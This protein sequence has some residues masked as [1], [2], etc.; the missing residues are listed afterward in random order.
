MTR[1]PINHLTA[2]DL[3]AFHSASLSA[4]VQEHLNECAECRALLEQDRALLASL[5]ALPR[6]GP[7]SGFADR[8][9]ARVQ[10]PQRALAPRFTP[11]RVALAAALVLTLGASIGWSLF[12]RALLVSWLD[13]GAGAIG[14]LLWSGLRVVASNLSQQPW[15]ATV[16]EFVAS[17]GRAP[18]AGSLLLLAYGGALFALRRLLVPPSPPVP[19]A[20]G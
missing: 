8:I 11:N 4:E 3:D 10:L 15:I 5:A 9:M 2:D 14:G 19:H 16:R 13:Q 12:N 20:N 7:S 18:V 1:W 6:F 17:S